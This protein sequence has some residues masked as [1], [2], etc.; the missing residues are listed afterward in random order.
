MAF[1]Y[2]YLSIH[3]FSYQAMIT[4]GKN[5]FCALQVKKR[6]SKSTKI[7]PKSL[8]WVSFWLENRF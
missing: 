2:D 8:K 7:S 1:F 6:V 3:Q 4:A 5:V